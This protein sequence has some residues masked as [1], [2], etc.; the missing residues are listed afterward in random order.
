[1]VLREV[2]VCASRDDRE[3]KGSPRFALVVLGGKKHKEQRE[4]GV[5]GGFREARAII[6]L[7]KLNAANSKGT[8]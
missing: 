7:I 6:L 1:M 3:G 8:G 2:S 4:R 5:E